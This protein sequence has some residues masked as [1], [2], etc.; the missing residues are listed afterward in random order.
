VDISNDTDNE[1]YKWVVSGLNNG[2][3]Y[4]N[5]KTIAILSNDIV[6]AGVIFSIDNNICWLS[7]FTSSPKWSTRKVLNQ[8]MDMAFGF[9]VKIVKCSVSGENKKIINFLERLG[10]WQEGCLRYGRADGSDEIV[11]SLTNEEW[12][13][14]R[15]Y[16]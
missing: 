8:I 6:I 15:W 16:K 2:E 14:K 7:I 5:D 10:W 11:Y 1:V 3:I 13:V 9:D 4:T 12:K